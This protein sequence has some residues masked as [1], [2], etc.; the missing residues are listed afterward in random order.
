MQTV[1][2]GDLNEWRLRRRSALGILEPKFGAGPSVLSFPSRRPLLALDRIFGW[3]EGLISNVAVHD[4]P[5]ARIASDHLPLT[6]T[7]SLLSELTMQQDAA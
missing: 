6:A 7:V 3:P 4:T 1:L 2:L 5:L